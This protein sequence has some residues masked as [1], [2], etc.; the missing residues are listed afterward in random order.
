MAEA[1]G[2]TGLE[3][4]SSQA[5]TIQTEAV[6]AV[7]N[8][9]G[10]ADDVVDLIAG[11]DTG[12]TERLEVVEAEAAGEVRVGVGVGD[13]VADDRVELADLEVDAVADRGA[14]GRVGLLDGHT[15]GQ[16][17]GHHVG[18]RA[19]HGLNLVASAPS[20]LVDGL[21]ELQLDGVHVEPILT[22]GTGVREAFGDLV[23]GTEVPDGRGVDVTAEG[24]RAERGVNRVRLIGLHRGSEAHHAGGGQSDCPLIKLH[25]VS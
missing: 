4:I 10:H 18:V 14:Q 3:A 15:R 16:G 21:L 8:A 1:V 23:S 7:G 11:Q 17:A 6:V 13:F 2:L 12:V 24:G 25:V 22:V 20:T 5:S 19:K 9:S